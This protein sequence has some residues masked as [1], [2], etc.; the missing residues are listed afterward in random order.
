MSKDSPKK[1][2]TVN[3][4]NNKTVKRLLIIGIILLV[5]NGLLYTFWEEVLSGSK[6]Q[7]YSGIMESQNIL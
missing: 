1:S 2:K 6:I 7:E 5:S 4:N 3:S